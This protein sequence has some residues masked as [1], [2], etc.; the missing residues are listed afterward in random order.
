MTINEARVALVEAI[1]AETGFEPRIE[2]S[3]LSKTEGNEGISN[4]YMRTLA[5]DKLAN[6]LWINL[7]LSTNKE[8]YYGTNDSV[9]VNIV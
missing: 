7:L 2:I 5:A 4:P 9:W 6:V 8:M 1:K 3:I